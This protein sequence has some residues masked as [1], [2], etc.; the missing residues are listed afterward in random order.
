MQVI[1]A[2]IFL[3]RQCELVD[4]LNVCFSIPVITVW[5]IGLILYKLLL[6]EYK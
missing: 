1:L 3:S 6:C 4:V 5:V 2:D